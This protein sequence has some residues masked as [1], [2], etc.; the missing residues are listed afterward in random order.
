MTF[1]HPLEYAQQEVIKTLSVAAFGNAHVINTPEIGHIGLVEH[2]N[3]AH[4]DCCLIGHFFC[5]SL[6]A[7][8]RNKSYT[9]ALRVQ[10]SVQGTFCA[11]D[12]KALMFSVALF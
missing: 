11:A 2:L 7:D 5:H 9:C 10:M 6:Q 8:S 12:T 3:G 1:G 4:G